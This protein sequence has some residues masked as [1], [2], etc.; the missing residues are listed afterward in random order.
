MVDFK[1]V[2]RGVRESLLVR[3]A[4]VV[5]NARGYSQDHKL[6]FDERLVIDVQPRP[7][8]EDE[9]TEMKHMGTGETDA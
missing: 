6:G 4:R 9:R 1:Q 8:P 5:M 7:K 3:A 2:H